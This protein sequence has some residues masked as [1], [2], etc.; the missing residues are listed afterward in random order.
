MRLWLGSVLIIL[1]LLGAYFSPVHAQESLPVE[2]IQFD[3]TF[4]GQLQAVVGLPEAESYQDVRLFTRS[5][6][7]QDTRSIPATREQ[8][9]Y[10]FSI[11]LSGQPLRP[12]SQ[13]EYWFSASTPDSGNLLSQVF[14]FSYDDNRFLWQSLEESPFTVYWYQGNLGFG[15][16]I[17]DSAQ[18]GLLKAQEL[19]AFPPPGQV[20]FYVYASGAEMQST[21]SL[22]GIELIG[23][24]ASPELGV[25]VVALPPG[26]GQQLEIDR[27][28]PHELMHVLLYHKLGTHYKRLPTWLNEGL[29]SYNERFPNPDYYLMLEN[30]QETGA[31][32]PLSTLCQPFPMEAYRFYLSYAE[33]ES[34]TRYLYSQVGVSGIEALLV[35]YADGLDCERGFQV[36]LGAPLTQVEKEWLQDT[37]QQTPV[38]NDRQDLFPW[39]AMLGVVLGAPLMLVIISF[40]RGRQ[41]TAK[42]G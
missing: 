2:V 41:V 3:Y 17:L 39:L 15:Q 10:Y 18:A 37:F 42:G 27:Q 20:R 25:V 28:I 24:H 31:L 29:A 32:I 36:A 26:P 23:G 34:F 13:V 16:A 35:Q 11:D 9:L 8:G 6:N 14:S 5:A 7:Q 30:A 33:A 19:L 12:F 4:G 22:A 40:W 38:A 21:L 1:M